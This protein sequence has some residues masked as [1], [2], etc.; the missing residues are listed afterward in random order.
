MLPRDVA[1]QVLLF[2]AFVATACLQMPQ[3]VRTYRTKDTLGLSLYTMLLRVAAAAC[4]MG[5]SLL[6]EEWLI[7]ASSITTLLSELA[8]IALKVTAERPLREP[9]DADA[10]A[11]YPAFST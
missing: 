1:S 6:V 8:L 4:W 9:Q 3:L 7:L 11:E 10:R 5:Y 2:T